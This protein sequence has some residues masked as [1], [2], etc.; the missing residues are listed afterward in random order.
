VILLAAIR[1]D[2]WNLALFVHVLGAMVLVGALALA[3]AAVAGHNP[4]LG[5]RALLLGAIP[6]WIAMRVGAQW[7]ASKE[8]LDDPD[9]D[10]PAWV[11]IG[12]ITSESSFLLLVAA[13]ICTGVAAR[14]ARGGGLRTATL[15]LVGIVLAAYVVAIWA[16]S[17]K[18]S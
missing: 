18:P 4:R 10:V 3:A 9:V 12:F 11:D 2:D 7:I 17:A 14:R 16:M 1:P 6:S 15:V 8:G 13:T 5:F